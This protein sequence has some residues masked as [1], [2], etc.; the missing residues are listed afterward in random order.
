MP[1]AWQRRLVPC[2]AFATRPATSTRRTPRV[3]RMV[4]KCVPA[5]APRTMGRS[6]ESQSM[7][8]KRGSFDSCQLDRGL[9]AYRARVKKT[10]H[11]LA[12]P[13]RTAV[14]TAGSPWF[15]GQHRGVTPI[16]APMSKAWLVVGNRA[17]GV[18]GQTFSCSTKPGFGLI[19]LHTTMGMLAAAAA[20]C[21]AGGQ[22]S[23]TSAQTSLQQTPC[24]TASCAAT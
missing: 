17:R 7:T 6:H 1:C 9:Q 13:E 11:R 19:H 8:T 21:T 12:P 5:D 16:P 3:L 24:H 22:P 20:T 10:H 14:G 18:V 4:F 23:R 2:H 15:P